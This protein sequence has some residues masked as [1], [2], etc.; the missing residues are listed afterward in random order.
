MCP[1]DASEERREGRKGEIHGWKDG[2]V[3]CLNLHPSFALI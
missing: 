2:M 3:G 1:S